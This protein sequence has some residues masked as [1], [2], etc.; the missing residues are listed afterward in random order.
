MSGNDDSR[1]ERIAEILEALKSPTLLPEE[2]AKL[3]TELD[4]LGRV[5]DPVF[6]GATVVPYFG[7]KAFKHYLMN[8]QG[9]ILPDFE[10]I[11]RRKAVLDQKLLGGSDEPAPKGT[12]PGST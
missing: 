7:Y 8:R 3:Q 2:R 6:D 12:G 11:R 9:S 4:S 10:S 1:I 5:L